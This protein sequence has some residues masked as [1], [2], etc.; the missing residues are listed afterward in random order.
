MLSRADKE[1]LREDL[2]VYGILDSS[3]GD[4]EALLSLGLNAARAGVG[5]LQVRCKG[6][7]GGD[8]YR[9]SR[10]LVEFCQP[11]GT[12]VV[13]NDRLDVALC[14]GADGVHLGKSDLPVREARR[15]APVDFIIGATARNTEDALRAQQDG[16]SY[17]GAGAAFKSPTKGDTVVI[18]P[19]GIS[20]VAKAISIPCVAIGGI[21]RDNLMDLI[22]TGIVGVA[23]CR[24]LFGPSGVDLSMLEAIRALNL[25]GQ[26]G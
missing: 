20:K 1:S 24:S 13:I 14:A 9:L 4:L 21:D 22:G 15:V 26:D 5:T 11:V 19:D 18:G 17:V 2:R 16:A 12:L 8:L 25:K 10:S 6:W 7:D 23:L 3:L